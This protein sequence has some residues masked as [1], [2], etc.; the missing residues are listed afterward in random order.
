MTPLLERIH[1]GEVL[2]SDGAMGTMLIARGLKSGESPEAF[3]L[4]RPEVLQEIARLYL[5]AG[6]EMVQTNTFGA[7]PL[8][9]AAYGLADRTEEINRAAVRAVREAV[10]D[11][12]YVMACCGTSG[13]LLKP[14]GDT[15]PEVVEA[16]FERQIRALVEAGIDAV[17][18]ETMIDLAEA[19]VAV[20]AARHVA[21]DLPLCATMTF[22]RRK[23]GF[24]T[25]MGN[26]IAQA[27]EGLANAG[28]DIIG[29]NCGNGI[30]PMVNIAREFR[31]ASGL[32]ISIRPNAGLPE[33]VNAEPFYPE[34]PEFMAAR[35]PDLLA[36]GVSIVGGCCGTTPKH[37]R[38]FRRV[39]SSF[40]VPS[41]QFPVSS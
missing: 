22:D 39:V 19:V 33:I 12:A 29:S 40:A 17:N 18:I 13:K 27:A 20:K 41:F 9:L 26:T 36:A 16:S 30:E 11:R 4:S 5:E 1:A 34:T 38:A 2:L 25:V 3:N 31:A 37:I 24:H 32:P 28:A 6:A 7:N 21:P 15:E 35:L 14:Y 10:D 23:K 8:K